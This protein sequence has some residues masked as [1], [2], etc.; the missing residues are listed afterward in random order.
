MVVRLT[1][2]LFVVLLMIAFRFSGYYQFHF[3]LVQPS[4]Q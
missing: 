2:F 1:L 4:Y 3:S